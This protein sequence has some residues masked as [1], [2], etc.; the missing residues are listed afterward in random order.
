MLG[1]VC[2]VKVKKIILTNIYPH[3]LF[4]KK[5]KG[6]FPI[7]QSSNEQNTM[8]TL[9][10][11]KGPLL[12]GTGTVGSGYPKINKGYPLFLGKLAS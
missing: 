2:D 5:H 1:S 7:N 6:V 10:Y 3:P 9:A 4:Y 11:D 8:H 12:G